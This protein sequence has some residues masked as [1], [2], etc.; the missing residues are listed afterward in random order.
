MS[1]DPPGLAL[2]VV[3]SSELLYYTFNYGFN[4]IFLDFILECPAFLCDGAFSLLL[5]LV[6]NGYDGTTDLIDFLRR[7]ALIGNEIISQIQ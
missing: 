4:Y 1:H 6:Y 3:C 7:N 5:S 2:L